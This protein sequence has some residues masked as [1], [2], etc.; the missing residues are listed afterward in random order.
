MHLVVFVL[1]LVVAGVFASL[2]T[3]KAIDAPDVLVVG[4]A[5]ICWIGVVALLWTRWVRKPS[6][7]L[8][9]VAAVVGVVMFVAT[10][11]AW[12]Q[13]A[14]VFVV[15]RPNCPP[16]V[17]SFWKLVGVWAGG[18]VALRYSLLGYF[19][20][21]PFVQRAPE[22]R[23]ALRWPGRVLLGAWSVACV[24]VL[25]R[26]LSVDVALQSFKEARGFLIFI[27]IIA[28]IAAVIWFKS[29]PG[30]K[31]W[32]QA[33]VDFAAIAPERRRA[34]VDIAERYA[35]G[36]AH[37]VYY[38]D[39]GPSGWDVRKAHLGGSMLM[40]TGEAWPVDD[41][42]TP[43]RALLQ[44][45]L[46]DALPAPWTGR[47]L[48]LWVSIGGFDVVARSYA[49]TDALVE[50]THP[51][52]T[53]APVTKGELFPLVLPVPENPDGEVEGDEFCDLLLRE[54]AELRDALAAVTDQPAAILPMLLQDDVRTLYL[55]PGNG[56]FVAGVP[57]LIQNEHEALC[58]IC[59]APMRFLL[60][61]GDFTED[62]AFGD[63]GV[64][65]V[66]G[67]DAHPAHCQAFVDCH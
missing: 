33:K 27:G 16:R 58:E 7:W 40:P 23:T 25:A 35:R 22:T 46:P 65:Y 59:R 24:Y 43:A 55:E 48:A 54:C 57:Q 28:L 44:L 61:S 66:Y 18:A 30:R 19:F 56:V 17:G 13:Q 50:V 14:D 21:P 8:A 53:A 6:G 29:I 20:G 5:L 34:L 9:R 42:G 41:D 60:S 36:V 37:C 10:V 4:A 2:F 51:P 45:P 47:S 3:A 62:M 32:K 63:V 31:R 49:S 11:Y 64:A 26:N 38:R 15:H 39:V 67:C 12:T 1:A 52:V